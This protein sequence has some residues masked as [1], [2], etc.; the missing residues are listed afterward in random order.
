MR[1]TTLGGRI[2]GAVA[3]VLAVLFVLSWFAGGSFIRD[4]HHREVELR[5]E[6]VGALLEPR[7]REWLKGAVPPGEIDREIRALDTGMRRR[8]TVIAVDGT[9]LADNVATLP[10]DNHAGRPEV[11]AA[12]AAGSGTS[13]RHSDS[14]G[15]PT[16][17][18]ARRIRDAGGT[19]GYLR[20]A[21]PLERVEEELASLGNGLLL[22]GGAVL[23]LGLLASWILARQ[24]ARPLAEME[25]SA[26]AY[27]E[28]R[29]EDRVR[30]SGP[31]EVTRLAV[32]L[33]R[34]ADQIRSRVEGEAR[35][36]GDLESVLAG[37]VEGVVA[38]DRREAV[39]F[40]NGSAARLLGLPGPLA[41]GSGLWEA[42]RFPALEGRFRAVLSGGSPG[43]GDAESP[44]RDG[45]LLNISVGPLGGGG[46][47]VALLRDVT[48]VR[49]LERIRM[50]FV[51]NVSHELRTPLT[52]VAGSLETLE[53]EGLDAGGRRRFL[54]IARRNCDRLQALVKDLLDL[55]SIES[56]EA[57][58]ET[59]P[60]P[61]DG[62]ARAAAAS[63]AG[64]AERGGVALAVEPLP[65][66]GLRVTGNGRRLEQ[67]LVN[68]LEN[69][70]KYTPAGGRITVRCIARGPEVACAVEDSGIGIPA[71][72]LPRIFER[73]YR[74]DP[75]R[76]R[77]MGGTGL[78]LAI[79]KHIARAHHGRVEVRSVEGAGTT[80]TLLLPR[81]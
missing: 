11:A 56:E 29:L 61:A 46:G 31:E 22:T 8:I 37:M 54:D 7:A 17:Y 63:L 4:F 47:A 10:L 72:S 13:I 30:T 77:G 45:R 58:L 43:A 32:S 73:F 38:V 40:M 44:A 74:V 78:G 28:G 3:G 65:V 59:E 24:L 15:F 79:V 6:A 76:S 53:D 33:N 36:R 60:L 34:M 16:L 70:L 68:L 66:P 62:A 42:L 27:A 55:S 21:E 39:L 25:R 12:A 67:A 2:F 41:A 64:L 20:V 26:A 5:L 69:A 80:F 35:V 18:F 19:L 51:A 71:E 14:T 75:S 23:L 49:R 9:V 50:D 52:G 1:R 48:E 81:A 57:A